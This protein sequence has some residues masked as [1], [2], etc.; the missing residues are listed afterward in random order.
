MR[1]HQLNDLSDRYLVGLLEQGLSVVTDPDIKHN[2]SP[3]FR[4]CDANLF[5]I[6]QNGRYSTGCYYIIEDHDELVACAGW[7]KYNDDTALVLTRAFVAENYRTSYI[8]GEKLLPLMI[9]STVAYKNVWITCNEYNKSIYNWFERKAAGRRTTMF[10]DWPEIYSRFEP[11]GKKIVYN[12][13]QYI[14]Q[15]KRQQH[16]D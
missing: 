8:M 5:Y 7:N 13:E 10:A 3:E 2:Y 6:L 1:I 14:V 9:H 4:E 15:L 12:T 16:N 11:I